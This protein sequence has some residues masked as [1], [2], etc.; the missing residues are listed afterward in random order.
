M[1][2]PREDVFEFLS[3]VYKE[4]AAL[5]PS[6]YIHIGGDEVIKK[7]WLESPIVKKINAAT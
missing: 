7:Q 4:V 2:C 5:F 1:L 3:V 6:K